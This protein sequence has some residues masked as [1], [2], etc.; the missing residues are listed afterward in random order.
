MAPLS[1]RNVVLLTNFVA[2]TG[3]GSYRLQRSGHFDGT[4]QGA[5]SAAPGVSQ[6]M[7]TIIAMTML[8]FPC[9]IPAYKLE[10]DGTSLSF[11]ET[12]RGRKR[13]VMKAAGAVVL[14]GDKRDAL[15]AAVWA[16]TADGR[17]ETTRYASF[18]P[19]WEGV[20]RSFVA[21]VPRTARLIKRIGTFAAPRAVFALSTPYPYGAATPARSASHV[22]AIETRGVLGAHET[23]LFP[24]DA[25]GT[26]LDHDDLPGSFA[27]NAHDV[28][29]ALR[30][31]GYEVVS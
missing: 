19:E 11:V 10:N 14:D 25:E 27:G 16:P 21:A 8:G 15:R 1:V 29:Y 5:R 24:C 4:K 13:R 9:A 22:V 6:T 30:G 18:A 2:G 17:G 31:L 26:I 12:S 23:K 20:I 3:T 7:H 28:R